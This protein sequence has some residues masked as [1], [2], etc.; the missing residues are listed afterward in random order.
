MLMKRRV[1]MTGK[2]DA[3]DF[4]DALGEWFE[5]RPIHATLTL[6]LHF[7]TWALVGMVVV[8]LGTR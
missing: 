8:A 3:P 5:K 7:A 2:V 1:G 6:A 4:L